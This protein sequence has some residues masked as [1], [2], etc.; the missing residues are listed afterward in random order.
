MATTT[1]I[2]AEQRPEHR[3]T[4]GWGWPMAIGILLILGGAFALFASVLTSLVSVLYI[5]LM[6]I[7]VGVFEIVS[8]FR[9]RDGR[10]R[11][12]LAG[13]LALVVGGLF[14]YRPLASL[15]SLTLLIAGYLFARGLFR[16]ITSILDRYPGWGWDLAYGIVAV[17]LGVYVAASWPFSSF[18]VLG[19]IV[20]AEIIACGIA[21]VAVS[22]SIRGIE[23]GLPTRAAM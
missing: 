2:G 10:S 13:V 14:L 6:L 8:A 17:A 23:H 7:V 5:G 20:A 22:L 19:T 15:A 1:G 16:G 12:F 4:V 9:V 3:H 21:L 11:Y 18:W